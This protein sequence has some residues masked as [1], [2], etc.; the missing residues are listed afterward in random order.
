MGVL[1][2]LLP[3]IETDSLVDKKSQHHLR[4]YELPMIRN[5]EIKVSTSNTSL[6]ALQERRK[7]KAI[8]LLDAKLAE[9][10]RESDGWDVK[11]NIDDIDIE[12]E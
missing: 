7:A 1:C 9:L 12:N 11:E 6:D 8:K 5:D 10:S 3:P 4:N 2:G